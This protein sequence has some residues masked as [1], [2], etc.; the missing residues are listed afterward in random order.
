MV[1]YPFANI[2]SAEFRKVG[3][4]GPRM[5]A[6]RRCQKKTRR[7]Y[8]RRVGFANQALATATNSADG[9]IIALDRNR[10]ASAVISPVPAIVSVGAIPRPV[11][12][13]AIT[14]LGANSHAADRRVNYDLSRRGCN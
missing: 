8:E 10:S 9:T 2:V 6:R 11:V 5:V 4:A 12:I 1:P 13:T 7:P 14:P 3:S